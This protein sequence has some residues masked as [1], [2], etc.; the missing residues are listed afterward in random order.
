MRQKPTLDFKR[1]LR[2]FCAEQDLFLEEK[3][4]NGPNE[5]IVIFTRKGQV[6]TRVA[7]LVL[8]TDQ[9]EVSPAFARA[10]VARL[11]QRLEQEVTEQTSVGIVKA[12]QDLAEWI[13]SW[14][15]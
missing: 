12:L 10:F 3:G 1:A 5:R 4:A 8:R 9:K 14:F 2:T 11:K 6:M 7:T 15:S 13:A